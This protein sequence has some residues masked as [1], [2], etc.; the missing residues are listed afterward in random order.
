MDAEGRLKSALAGRYAIEREIGRGGMATV[1]LAR[2]LKHGRRV[3]IKVLRP[4]LAATLGPER[5]IREIEI[6]ANLSHPHILPLFDS[7]EADGL[8]YYVMPFVE[9]EALRERLDREGK[10][11]VA[12]A[13]RLTDEIASALSYAHEQGI[14]HRDV[15]PENIMLSGGRAVVAD[16]GIGRAL[17]AAGGQPLTGTGFAVG[18]PAYMSPEQ[19]FGEADLDGRSDVYALGCVVYEMV[20]GH[21][22]FQAET[23]QAQ[24]A[25]H[26]AGTVKSMRAA[27]PKIPLFLERAVERALAKDPSERFQTAGAFAQALTSEMVVAPTAKRRRSRF[28]AFGATALVV[29]A[30]VWGIQTFMSRPAY[31]R[32]AV[33]PPT[34]L[35]ND[36]E[37][38][39]LVKGM[40][41]ALISEL[42]RAGVSVIARTSV[43]QYADTQM[44]IRE[45]AAQLGV[46][47]LI[48]SS[49]FRAGDSVEM[50]VRLVDGRTQQYVAE[51]IIRGS[52]LQN[53]LTL[54]RSL[55]RAIASEIHAALTPQAEAVLADARPVNQ[56]AYEAFVRGQFHCWR[57]T[58][59]DLEQA[60]AYFQRSLLLDPTYAPAQAGIA[61]VWFG[62]GFFGFMPSREAAAHGIE[63]YREALAMDSTLAETQYAAALIRTW[64]EWDWEGAE[65]AFERAIEINPNY[66]D[67]IMSYSAYLAQ[68]GRSEEARPYIDRALVLDPVNPL[69]RSFN[70]FRMIYERRYAEGIEEFEEARRIEPDNP[71][72]FANLAGAYF[73]N[74]DYDE[75]L[76][77]WRKL[78][79]DDEEFQEV[80]GLGY[81]E[82]GARTALVRGAEALASRPGAAEFY[83]FVITYMF[84]WA[85]ERER[86][87]DW[88]EIMFQTRNP[89]LV[90]T[91]LDPSLDFVVDDPRYQ[92]LLRRVDFPTAQ[93]GD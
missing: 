46:D 5:F 56:E 71:A 51:P 76:A 38:E 20:S 61:W 73:L 43:L 93:E 21:T 65:T 49:V 10:L 8:L 52:Q 48:E 85:G 47:A 14:V 4:E 13:V 42:Q 28:I 80:L 44:P 3:A 11:P 84:A 9:G 60:L 74:G 75:G 17:A 83:P 57:L 41:D 33:L 26:A 62:M 63:A 40:H 16:F 68:T 88:L 87:L 89:T 50:E 72:V 36:P 39:Y 1:Y 70:G 29:L 30:A 67:A 35:T 2:D 79:A 22:P 81:L 91:F 82:G 6:A 53:V 25:K 54:Y 24:M 92:E 34:N 90:A 15:K 37:Q 86:T 77:M 66:A 23:P 58:P 12:E 7:G 32:L 69:A 27:D 31:E 18:T 59:A 19:A 45:I 55:T 64:Y 78:L